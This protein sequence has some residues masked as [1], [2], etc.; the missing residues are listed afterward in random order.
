[1]DRFTRELA[2]GEVLFDQGDEGDCAYII[3]SG[4]I[5]ICRD[6]QGAN[7]ILARLGPQEIFG[8]MALFGEHTRSAAARAAEPTRLTMVTHEYLGE[9]VQ[10]ADPMLR[11]LL[12]TLTRRC[13]ELLNGP[14]G[15]SG[16]EA[17]ATADDDDRSLALAR[18][19]PSRS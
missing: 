19:T 16:R 3:E 1:M 14:G 7:R 9:R 5:D 10:A 13:R 18:C 2:A 15:G 6:P 11:H 4:L 12:R 17:A 8:E